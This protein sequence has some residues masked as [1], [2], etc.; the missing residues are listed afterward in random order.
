MSL[1]VN[2]RC[3]IEMKKAKSEQARR[4]LDNTICVSEK[5]QSGAYTYIGRSDV[6][7]R[8]SGPLSA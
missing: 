2:G 5:L 1:L 7:A 4:A 6:Q 3:T 8:G